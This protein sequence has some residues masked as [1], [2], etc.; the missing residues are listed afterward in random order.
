MRYT[1]LILVLVCFAATL[2][3]AEPFLGTWKLNLAKSHYSEGAPPK[4]QILKIT[5]EGS[6]LHVRVDAITANGSKTVVNYTIPVEGGMG[7]MDPSPAYDGILGRH[8]SANVREIVRL[9]NGKEVFNAHATV[10]P[11]GKTMSAHT[12]GV[13]PLGLP[14]DSTLFYEKQQ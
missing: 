11:D 2:S 1:R 6:D 8:L 13:S 10:A 5:P 3:A 14:V 4:E 7:K 12:T 9:K